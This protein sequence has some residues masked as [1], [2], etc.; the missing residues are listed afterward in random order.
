MKVKTTIGITLSTIIAGSAVINLS[1]LE[2]NEREAVELANL[3]NDTYSEKDFKNVLSDENEI[4]KALLTAN[5]NEYKKE[6]KRLKKEHLDVGF[7][8]F[9][10]LSE[11]TIIDEEVKKQVQQ[12]AQQRKQKLSL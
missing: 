11:K 4:K 1:D 2:T 8:H 7:V 3:F 10:S 5:Y 12:Q 9:K 6:L